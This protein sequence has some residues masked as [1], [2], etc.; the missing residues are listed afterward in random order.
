MTSKSC[1]TLNDARVSSAT[2]LS[3]GPFFQTSHKSCFVRRLHFL[4]VNIE[5]F[6]WETVFLTRSRISGFSVCAVYPYCI[7]KL[8]RLVILMDAGRASYI[9]DTSNEL[10][11]PSG[12]QAVPDHRWKSAARLEMARYDQRSGSFLGDVILVNC[13]L[14][15]L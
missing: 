2:F 1:Q 8:D 15:A 7:G 6:F 5:V 10:L 4:P 9:R 13:R 3:R 14:S 12:F 11:R